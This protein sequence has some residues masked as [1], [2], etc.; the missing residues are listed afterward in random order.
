M[1]SYSSAGI[2]VEEKSAGP[3][4][5]G[6]VSTANM[7]TVGFTPR[8]PENEA[9][10]VTSLEEYFRVFGNH[11]NESL[12]SFGVTAFF[13]NGGTSAYIVR[14]TPSDAVAS[15][16]GH[17][18]SATAAEETCRLHSTATD[19][20]TNLGASNYNIA[21]SIDNSDPKEIDVTGDLG[22]SSPYTLSDLVS[23]INTEW[24]KAQFL[25][26][27]V[28][29]PILTLDGTHYN[30]N[31]DIDGGG[32][33]DIDVTGDNGVA[34]TYALS[35]IAGNI[36]TA[37]GS[38]VCYVT[39]T[40]LLFKAGTSIVFAAPSANDCTNLLTGL[41]EGA[42][43]HSY[44]SNTDTICS[45]D[46]DVSFQ[47]RLVFTSPTTGLTSEVEF[48]APTVND[49]TELLLGLDE[50]SYPH[51][52]KGTD[53]KEYWDVVASSKGVWGD[54]LR[55]EIEPNENYFDATTGAYTKFDYIVYE[56]DSS[57]T[58]VEEERYESVS[59]SDNTD[60]RYLPSV[61]NDESSLIELTVDTDG[62]AIM[63]A[64]APISKSL[65]SIGYGT[66]ALAA[67]TATL[68]VPTGYEVLPG[69]LTVHIDGGASLGAD[70]DAGDGTGTIDGGTIDN[71]ASTINY[72]TGAVTVTFDGGSEPAA[73]ANVQITYILTPNGT[74]YCDLASGSDGTTSL[75]TRTT[76]TAPALEATKSGMYA[77]NDVE[78]SFQLAIPDF[79]YD[80]TSL[81][82]QISYAEGR[83]DVFVIGSV[84]ENNSAT[85]AAKWNRQTLNKNTSY[86]AIYSPWIKIAD[87]LNEGRAKLMPSCGHV[88]GVYARTD[89]N[90]NVGKAPAG[91]TDGALNY[92]I[93]LESR[94]SKGERD[95]LYQA[96]VNPLV[97][98]P[99]TGRAVWGA[100]TVSL[101]SEWRYIQ[102]RRLFIFCKKSTFNDTHWAVFENNDELLWS[103]IK[104]QL[105]GFLSNL[106]NDGYFKGATPS[107]AFEVIVDSSNNTQAQIDA[108]LVTVDV[109]IA[110][111]KPGE[112]VRFRF[113]QKTANAV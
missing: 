89:N 93:G 5:I 62:P 18:T 102:A 2:Y 9:T 1:A 92:C 57:G 86:L 17:N 64:L 19:G 96:R 91:I 101:D 23:T 81:D 24:N 46:T 12:I 69:S 59:I 6:P 4:A 113:S 34:G 75:I 27:A 47:G 77:L 40:K 85:N 43:P 16:C 56:K 51:T 71:T 54:G 110:P 82:D 21:V 53:L 83:E 39:G 84:P 79:C 103:R 20:I 106:Y 80:P 32:A 108:G 99:Y 38:T 98:S 73:D 8:G 104:L 41:D 58:Y 26:A 37:V 68:S 65:F 67:F 31:L 94:F 74:V 15:S 48:S 44:A 63:E 105:T 72:T 3:G 30:I 111:N 107:E 45:I 76:T 22:A 42:Y 66:G 109:G 11:W 33:A 78:D 14:V 13:K 52:Y 90:V 7:A 50:A 88:A 112:F 29:D 95:V 97:D 49:C 61:V 35:A 87:P 100:R 55:A 70:T 36:N 28:T 60:A 10:L 25:G